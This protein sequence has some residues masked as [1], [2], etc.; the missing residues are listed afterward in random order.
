MKHQKLLASC[1]VA[2]LVVT[3]AVP[4]HGAGGSTRAEETT[5]YGAQNHSGAKIDTMKIGETDMYVY[6]PVGSERLGKQPCSSPAILVYGDGAYTADSAKAE[7]EATG[8][9]DIAYE[10]GAPIV[11]ANP[12]DGKAWNDKN[13]GGSYQAIIGMFSADSNT[14]YVDGKSEAGLY[15]GAVEKGRIY[16]YA[17]GKGADFVVNN[18]MKEVQNVMTFPDGNSIAFDRTATCITVFDT[19]VVPSGTY[20]QYDIPVVY[21]NASGEV[22]EAVRRLNPT[23]RKYQF[24]TSYKSGFDKD[25]IRQTYDSFTGRIRRQTGALIEIPKYAELGIRETTKTYT[26]GERPIE[27]IE[28]VPTDISAAQSKKVPLVMIFHGGGSTAEYLGWATE[29]PLIA[30]RDGFIVVAVNAHVDRSAS[31]IVELLRKIEADYPCIDTTRVYA[32]GF[33][34]GSVKSWQLMEQYPT[35]FAGVAP[36]D[37]SEAAQY[38]KY[39]GNVITPAF[40]VGGQTSP[41]PEFPHQA[42]EANNIDS[43]VAGLFKVNKVSD[44]YA[45]D[46]AANKWWGAKPYV[47]QRIENKVFKD[48]YLNLNYYKSTDGNIYTVLCDVEN[49]SHEE[50]AANAYAAWDF[51]KQF[52]RN[53]DGS[54]SVDAAKLAKPS[55]VK[56]GNTASGVKVT[57]KSVKNALGYVVQRKSG[58]KWKTV[59]TIDSPSTLSYTDKKANKN[60]GT[61]QYRVC[62]IGAAQNGTYSSAVTACYLSAGKVS[63]AKS[64][65]S[66]TAAVQWTKNAKADGYQ[67][68]C[69]T[70]STTKTVTVKSAA[71]VKTTLKK[72]AKNKTYTVSVRAYKKVSGKTYYSAWSAAKKVKVK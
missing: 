60:G 29:W 67:I 62:A 52:S 27:Y 68:R 47:T 20:N 8:L 55:S 37:G 43:R 38:E 6:V 17:A 36:M 31:E 45:Y 11:F 72:L 14:V 5:L 24:P 70:G 44:N 10:E 41:L 57:W 49:Q 39:V 18:Y 63:S 61:Y 16:I 2:A 34:M 51:L 69:T 15:A 12:S 58:D 33:S 1:L 3:G 65:T 19:A 71:T 54:I 35:L 42:G 28:Y 56:A 22:Q 32:S 25:I 64:S 66:K 9:A 21:T 53:A 7:A 4:V 46:A 23:Y 59:K 13:D 26:V 30:K 48:C 40:F 50:Y